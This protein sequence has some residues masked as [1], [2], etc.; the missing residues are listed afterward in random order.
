MKKY[1]YP[2][3]LF[4]SDSGY[5]LSNCENE[6]G[7]VAL[8]YIG[9]SKDIDDEKAADHTRTFYKVATKK[10]YTTL[11]KIVKSHDVAILEMRNKDSFIKQVAS[12]VLKDKLGTIHKI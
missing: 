6:P 12:L 2:F 9:E 8:A 11:K 7:F 5:W 1:K 4:L 10:D 3:T